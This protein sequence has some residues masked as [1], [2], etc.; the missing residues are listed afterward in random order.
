MLL[1]AP[2]SYLARPYTR[3]STWRRCKEKVDKGDYEKYK[4]EV[5][6]QP[7]MKK[8]EMIGLNRERSSEIKR[9]K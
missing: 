6:R 5:E 4:I 1:H 3:E 2:H 9:R 8:V 7:E